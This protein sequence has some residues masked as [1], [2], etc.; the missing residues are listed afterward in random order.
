[1]TKGGF[2]VVKKVYKVY[3]EILMMGVRVSFIPVSSSNLES[4]KI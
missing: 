2:F 3:K 4:L 1:M